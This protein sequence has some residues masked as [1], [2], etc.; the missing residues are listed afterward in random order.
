MYMNSMKAIRFPLANGF[1]MIEVLA[2]LAAMAAIGAIGYVSVSNTKTNA[3]SEKLQADVA[4]INRSIQVFQSQG[5]SLTGLTSVDDVL[6]K[7]KT[8]ASDSVLG[9]SSS[10]LDARVYAFYQTTSEATASNPRAVW[11]PSKNRFE[12]VYTGGVGVKEFR[13][14][15]DLAG[16]A[17]TVD[18][19]RTTTKQ[20][21][22]GTGWEWDYAVPVEVASTTGSTP[23]IG[24]ADTGSAVLGNLGLDV[25][26]FVVDPNG[27]GDVTFNYGYR[28][29]GYNQRV[30]FFSLDGMDIYDLTTD[31][32][33]KAFLLE[34]MR[35]VLSNSTDGHV[36]LDAATSTPGVTGNTYNFRPGDHLG[37]IVIPNTNF[38]SALT[39]LANDTGSLANYSASHAQTSPLVSVAKTGEDIPSFYSKQFVDVGNGVV[40]VEDQPTLTTGAPADYQD[41]VFT[42]TGMTSNPNMNKLTDANGNPMSATAYYTTGPGKTNAPSGWTWDSK[43]NGSTMS[44]HQFLYNQGVAGVSEP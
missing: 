12:V 14:N 13:L 30:G 8:K 32:G 19:T 33:R 35:R 39:S 44:L 36:V 31:A 10:A 1:T 18:T 6:N 41:V 16:E 24:I 2:V 3:D 26:D 28:E 38:Q 25:G 22:S 5:G 7:L 40:A 15:E 34:A 23:Q 4:S 11:T 42:T 43:T 20:V 17:P 27:N 29:A 21:N 37:A 9:A